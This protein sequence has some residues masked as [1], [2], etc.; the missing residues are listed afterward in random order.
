MG[1]FDAWT[2]IIRTEG[3]RVLWSG[4]IS[5]LCVSIPTVIIYFTSYM[6]VKELLGYNERNPTPILPVAAGMC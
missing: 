3:F 1:T 5:N 2:K 6:T 4:L